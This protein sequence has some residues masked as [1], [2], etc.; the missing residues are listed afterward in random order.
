MLNHYAKQNMLTKYRAACKK[1]INLL[2][3]FYQ[4]KTHFHLYFNEAS[5]TFEENSTVP[6][7]YITLKTKAVQVTKHNFM[8]VL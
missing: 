4:F 3:S 6:M 1:P 5:S 7:S 2:K 8:D